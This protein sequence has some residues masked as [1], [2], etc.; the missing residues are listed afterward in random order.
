MAQKA[1]PPPPGFE[2]VD[3]SRFG[4]SPGDDIPA[5]PPA[6]EMLPVE[7]S[8]F[9]TLKGTSPSMM[10]RIGNTLYDAGKAIGLPVEQMRRDNARLDAGVRGV[11]DTLTWSTADEI[12]AKAADLTGIGGERGNYEGNLKLQRAV[13]AADEEINP[14]ARFAGQIAGGIGNAAGVVRSGASLGA[15]AAKGG[16]GW[17]GRMLG[18]AA[19]G[20]IGAALYGAGSGEGIADRLQKA[21]DN[22]PAGMA[23]GA[24]GDLAANVLGKTFRHFFRGA[25]DAAPGINPAASVA[26]ADQFGIPLSRAQATQSVKQANVENQLRAQGDMTG[27]DEAQRLAITQSVDGVQSGLAGKQPRIASASSA[28]DNVP[29]ALRG[30]RDRLKAGSQDAYA[31]SVDNPDVLVSGQAVRELPSFIA[32]KLDEN[33]IIVDPMYHTGAAR[34]LTY[35]NTY[36]G[37]MPKTGNGVT[38][39]QAQLRWIENMRAGVRKNYPPIGQD[40]PA[41]RAISRAMDEWVDDIFDRGLVSAD[42][43]VLAELKQ[44][45]AGWSEYMGMAEPKARGYGGKPNPR[46]EA[47]Q[48]VRAIM[49]KEMSPE[50][51]G[52]LLWGT[53]VAAP[54]QTSFMTALELRNHLGPDSPEWSGIRQSFWLRATRANDE[55]M[56]PSQIAKNLQGFLG[57]DGSP[58]SAASRTKAHIRDVSC[59]LG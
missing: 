8:G 29:A 57:G 21:T 41:L 47:Q 46:Y 53:S 31:A 45:R 33:Q 13:D 6:F 1:P 11:A 32:R 10:E 40:A 2:L 50:E 24:G 23:F 39:V 55:A 5:P 18:S 7:Q 35:I 44:A 42:D 12:A 3:E 56:N 30:K 16:Y 36:L 28:Y 22:A 17:F 9:G 48:R 58:A 54:R 27:F 34:A 20:G 25:S 15:R 43:A 59:G 4:P 52:R 14:G 19:D 26:D 51:V 38:D 49:D 37:R